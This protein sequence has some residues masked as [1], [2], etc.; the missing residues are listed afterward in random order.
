MFGWKKTCREGAY[1]KN[2]N[3]SLRGFSVDELDHILLTANIYSFCASFDPHQVGSL[4][5]VGRFRFLLDGIGSHHLLVL[6]VVQPSQLMYYI[7]YLV[8]FSYTFAH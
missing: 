1:N 8:R 4:P 6:D 5:T 2:D 3:M 7:K